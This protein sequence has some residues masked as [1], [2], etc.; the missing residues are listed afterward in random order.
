MTRKFNKDLYI[1]AGF[2]TI[3]LGTGRKEFNPKKPRPGISHYIAEAGKGAVKQINAAANV[4]ECVIA[5]FM[6]AR[7]V[8]QA[9]LAAFAALIDPS[10]EYKPSTRVEGACCSG[11]LG[12]VASM[13]NVLS[14]LAD[15]SMTVGVEVQNS[16][17]AIYGADILAGAGYFEGFRKEG[18]AYFLSL[19]HI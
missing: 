4:D 17:K 11:G 18:H 1:T 12:L 14:G 16:V 6:A 9:N 15:V 10:F 19:I 13:K 8:K 5:N 2:N 7:F 3:C